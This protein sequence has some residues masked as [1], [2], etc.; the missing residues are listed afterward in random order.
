VTRYPKIGDLLIVYP[1][2]YRGPY[3]GSPHKFVGLVSGIEYDK[4]GHQENV[5]VT[6]QNEPAW[7]YQT[8]HGYAGM[9]IHNDRN[10]FIIIRD[11][12]TVN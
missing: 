2:G 3:G 5:F 6:W 9:N 7:G 10:R 8:E 1:Q 12:I 11:G 4:W